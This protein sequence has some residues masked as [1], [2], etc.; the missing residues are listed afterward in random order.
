MWVKC[1]AYTVTP[2]RWATKQK[3]CRWF[4]FFF[5]FFYNLVIQVTRVTLLQSYTTTFQ[6]SWGPDFDRCHCNTLHSRILVSPWLFIFGWLN[7]CKTRP[8]HQPTTTVLG[9]WYDVIVLIYCVWFLPKMGEFA[10]M[11]TP[12]KIG[13]CPEC[14]LLVNN[15]SD[16]R[17]INFRLI[18]NALITLETLMGSNNCFFKIP[19]SFL[20]C[21]LTH[22]WMLQTSKLFKFTTFTDVLT[23]A[24]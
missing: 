24:D 6:S 23:L 2:E 10:E 7:S 15:L 12:E 17:M 11:S 21:I 19:Y 1:S 13:S 14:F 4:F 3:L 8:N 9:S 5:L 18:R 16:S 20:L 22:T